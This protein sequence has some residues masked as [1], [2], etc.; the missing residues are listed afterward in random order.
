MV[1]VHAGGPGIISAPYVEKA[2]GRLNALDDVYSPEF[3]AEGLVILVYDTDEPPITDDALT[4]YLKA[5]FAGSYIVQKAESK[6]SWLEGPYFLQGKELH[7]AWR[8]YPDYLCA[9]T[10]SMVP[11]ESG[12]YR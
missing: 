3:A 6:A 4:T 12:P 9:F 2:L 11:D 7:Q 1:V 10:S 5:S 8:L